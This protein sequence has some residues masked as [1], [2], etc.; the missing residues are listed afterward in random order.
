MKKVISTIITIIL[1]AWVGMMAYDYYRASSK[2]EPPVI[3]LKEEKHEYS[4]G[5]V[6]E[7][8]GLGYKY[9]VYRRASRNGYM[10]GGFWIKVE[11]K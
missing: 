9:I 5:Y 1:I 10:F 11:E 8:T 6:Q 3:I 7:Y 4:D 2:N